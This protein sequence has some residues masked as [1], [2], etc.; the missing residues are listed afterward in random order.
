MSRDAGPVDPGRTPG[1]PQVDPTRPGGGRGAGG[2]D[3]RAVGGRGGSGG[4][5]Q[6]G[7]PPVADGARAVRVWH[8][9]DS[10][11]GDPVVRRGDLLRVS[12]RGPRRLQAPPADRRFGR[13]TVI[14]RVRPRPRRQGRP[15]VGLVRA[16][17]SCGSEVV[18]TPRRTPSRADAIVW[19]PGPRPGARSVPNKQPRNEAIGPRGPSPRTGAPPDLDVRSGLFD[20]NDGAG[21]PRGTARLCGPGRADLQGLLS[22]LLHYGQPARVLRWARHAR[23]IAVPSVSHRASPV[24]R[25]CSEVVGGAQGACC[26]GGGVGEGRAPGWR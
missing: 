7:R 3:L 6:L 15:I 12:A 24:A 25:A 8:G 16:R 1:G 13:L 23:A 4:A 18:G 14:A 2:A 5:A 19:L 20:S 9:A 22:S 17:C 11:L 21:R 10:S 26:F